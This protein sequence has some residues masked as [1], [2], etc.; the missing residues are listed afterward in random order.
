MGFFMSKM[1]IRNYNN[2]VANASRGTLKQSIYCYCYI[3]CTFQK[4]YKDDDINAIRE[5][6]RV[7]PRFAFSLSK[8]FSC[9]RRRKTKPSWQISLVVMP[10]SLVSMQFHVSLLSPPESRIPFPIE[11]IT[12]GRNFDLPTQKFRQSRNR[13]H[14]RFCYCFNANQEILILIKRKH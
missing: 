10:V 3:F 11:P 7:Q 6:L 5:E 8:K 1:Q 14:K 12:V 13:Q 2:A 9:G 4:R